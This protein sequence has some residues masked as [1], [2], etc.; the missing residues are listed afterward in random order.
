MLKNADKPAVRNGL[1]TIVF[2]HEGQSP[3]IK[4][5]QQN[6]FIVIEGKLPSTR[7]RNSRPSFRW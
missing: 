3:C 6:H 7:T 5:G 1:R 4:D 2:H